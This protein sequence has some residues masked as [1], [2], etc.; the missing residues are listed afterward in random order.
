[1][2][3]HDIN[4]KKD[5]A[6]LAELRAASSGIEPPRTLDPTTMA[7]RAV[8]NVRR[9]RLVTA[10]TAGA[11]ALAVL[12]AG[13]GVAGALQ[14]DRDGPL[15]GTDR[16]TAEPTPVSESPSPAVSPSA[17]RDP[18]PTEYLR[19]GGGELPVLPGVERGV[20]EGD[21]AN[22]YILGG[23]WY[24]VP[25]GGWYAVGDVNAGGVA[26]FLSPEDPR[27]N[28]ALDMSID[29]IDA[30]LEL[31]NVT[32][33]AGWTVPARDSGAMTFA[34]EGAD[35]V[36]IEQHARE[37]AVAPAT[38]RIRSGAEG[39]V[40]E[41]RF[42]AGADGDRMLRDFVGNLWLKEAGEPD[43]YA[44]AYEHPTLEPVERGIPAGWRRTEHNGLTFGVPEGWTSE[45]TEGEFSPGVE[46]TGP[47][48]VSVEPG[49]D[50]ATLDLWADATAEEKERAAREL[51]SYERVYVQGGEPGGNWWTRT[52]TE[53]DSQLIEV[54]GADYAEA[55]PTLYNKDGEPAYYSVS[56]YVHQADRGENLFLVVDFAGGEQGWQ[57]LHTFL[58]TL[59]FRR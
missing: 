50:P 58:G 42:P 12:A 4:A 5:A 2:S 35:L 14:A 7:V 36:V 43:W 6:M 34:I 15:P 59:D 11:A 27:V 44:P 55:Q 48:A 54:P 39:W 19:T 10:V 41:T 24:E 18:E 20:V 38:I 22:P 25:P 53:P 21:G 52:M 8:R 47:T 45:P 56:I 33:V 46:W 29:D 40:I 49:L 37:G 13:I 16:S 23:L 9:R 32:D 17:G 51:V 28:G 26:G 31:R 3:V 57:D 1:M 30:T